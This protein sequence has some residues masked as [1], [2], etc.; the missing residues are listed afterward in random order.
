MVDSVLSHGAE[1]WAVQPV[2]AAV[3]GSTRGG[4]CGSGSA[5][6]SLHMGYL[7]RLL[8][9]RQATP[10]GAVLLETGE[11]PLWVRWLL[12]A[13]R[14]WNRLATAPQGSLLHA[15][16]AVSRQLAVTAPASLP[17]ARQSWAAQLAAA[18]LGIGMPVDLEQPR[19]LCLEQLQLAA[20]GRHLSEIQAAAGRPGATKLAHYL[21]AAWGGNLPQPGEYV[22]LPAAYL[23]AVRQRIR[24]GA[25]AQLRTGSHWLAEETGRWEQVP[26]AQRT[27][28]H[29][30]GGIED[31]QH[32]LFVCP[33]YASVRARFPDLVSQTTVHAFL[34]QDPVLVATFVAECQRTHHAAAAARA[35]EEG[36][37]M[38]IVPE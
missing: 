13:V 14:L 33:L 2:A 24:R 12:R 25:L 15:A 19:P 10:N 29:C 16:F 9:V 8:G 35:L 21:D 11:R 28:P 3:A 6:E 1:V 36:A 22:P 5:A 37:A 26:C 20:M 7:R 27:C 34:R 38:S 32:V 17:L 31:V 30:Q 4:M 18:L 23:G